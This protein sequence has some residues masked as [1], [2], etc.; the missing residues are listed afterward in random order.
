MI[1]LAG[2][3]LLAVTIGL[4]I[5]LLGLPIAAPRAA[6][7][8]P[9]DAIRSTSEHVLQVLDDQ[10]LKQPDRAKERR[11][12]LDQIMG[13]RFSYEEMSKRA[14][15]AQWSRL[16]GGEKTEF[17]SLFQSLLSATYTDRI[18]GHGRDEIRYVK[19]RLAKGYAEVQTTVAT[20]KA[21]LPIHFRMLEQSGDWLVYDV[22]VDGTSLV[23]NYRG[24]F[25]RVLADSSYQSLLEKLRRKVAGL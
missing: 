24:Q 10:D 11:A 20:G 7:G 12:R 2:R 19:E 1:R 13:K 15:G 23:S 9:T 8:P 6:A 25:A 5:C 17:V 14:L 16:T 22:I 21:D 3:R 4:Q 18:E